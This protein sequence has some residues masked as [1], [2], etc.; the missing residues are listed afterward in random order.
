[1][2]LSNECW[3][4]S[5]CKKA[6]VGN[7]EDNTFC[8]KLFKLN[9]LYDNALISNI[10]RRRIGL[11]YDANGTDQAEFQ[12]LAAIQNNIEENVKN[13]MNLYIHSTTCG[14]GKTSWALRMIQ[15]YF[16]AIWHKS[17]IQCKALFIN[18][19]R[20]MLAIKDNISERSDYVEHIKRNIANADLVIWDDIGTKT[21]TQFEAENLL[22]MLDIR[23]N[24]GKANI[25]TSNMSENELYEV[26][27]QRLASRVVNLSENIELKGV[28]KRVLV[29]GVQ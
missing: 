4:K 22:S 26:L 3:M 18:V 17:D 15:A 13:G 16:E 7:C 27:G 20:F 9:A 5:Q 14:N 19:P 21:V 1:M 25:F 8:I 12:R 29:G 24:S 6:L 2:I 11:R 10:Q 28:D 23:I